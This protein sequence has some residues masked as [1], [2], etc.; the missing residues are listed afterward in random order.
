MKRHIYNTNEQHKTFPQDNS[1]LHSTDVQGSDV[2]ILEEN[3]FYVHYYFESELVAD[4]TQKW[5]KRVENPAAIQTQQRRTC[6]R[7]SSS[8]G[9][10]ETQV[11]HHCVTKSNIQQVVMPDEPCGCQV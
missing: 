8:A 11:K 3:V 2:F 1:S 5:R 6:S 7:S 10:Q 4:Q 9:K